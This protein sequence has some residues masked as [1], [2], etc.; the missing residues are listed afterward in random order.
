[1]TKSEKL[2]SIFYKDPEVISF[3]EKKETNDL[4]KRIED[5]LSKKT[6]FEIK[7]EMIK[8]EPGEPGYTPVKGKDYFTPSEISAFKTASTPVKGVDYYTDIEMKAMLDYVTPIKGKDYFSDSEIKSIVSKVKSLIPEPDKLDVDKLVETIS[9]RLDKPKSVDSAEDIIAKINTV[10][11]GIEADT[12]KGLPTIQTIVKE[13]KKGKLLDKS[14]IRGMR[15][16]DQKW[17]GGGATLVAGTGITITPNS[18]GTTTISGSSSTGFQQ[19]T[20]GALNQSTFVWATAPNVIVVDGVPR[21]KVQTDGTINWTGTTTTVLA[22]WP[23]FD[24]FSTC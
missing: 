10:K 18:N 21:Q 20:S 8:G 12:I 14:D 23:S 15:L 5:N 19:P 4:L 13:I 17:H 2:K 7:A 9:H 22:Q 1:M 24:I 6:S 11:E 16:D 3:I